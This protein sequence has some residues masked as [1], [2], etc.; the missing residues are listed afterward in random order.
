MKMLILFHAL[1]FLIS[2]Y[3]VN[4]V[5]QEKHVF[6]IG[7]YILVFNDKHKEQYVDILFI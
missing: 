3:S 5:K 4:C 6:K 7:M 1:F 2:L